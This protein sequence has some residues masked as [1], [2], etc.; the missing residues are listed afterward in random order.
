MRFI[1]LV[2]SVL[3][4]YLGSLFVVRP[5]PWRS[6]I[7]VGFEDGLRTVDHEEGCVAGGSTGGC[8]QAPE[9]RRK[10]GDPSFAEL[11]QPV[12]DSG[13]KTL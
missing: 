11:V 5:D 12:E 1:Q 7:K 6:I 3:E 2:H 4:G 10:L 13:L 8:P 9:Y